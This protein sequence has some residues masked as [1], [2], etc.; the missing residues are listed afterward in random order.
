MRRIPLALAAVLLA[1]VP[2]FAALAQAPAKPPA[3]TPAKP[4]AGAP[5]AGAPVDGALATVPVLPPVSPEAHAEAAKLTEMIGVNRQSQ[6]LVGIMRGQMIQ[7]VMHSANKPPA[8]ATKIV[9][10]VLMPDFLAQQGQLTN[11][12]VD[13]WARNFTLEDIK[14]LEAFYQTPLGQKLIHTLPAVTQEGMQAGQSWGQRIYQ[15]DIAK[16]KDELILR[17]LKF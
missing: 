14:G 7:L 17:G 5:V 16:H 3:A 9:D 12:I 1:G 4:P 2:T 6:Q 15:A 10:E 13:V 11:D 8:E